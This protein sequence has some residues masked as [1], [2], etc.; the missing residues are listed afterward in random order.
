VGFVKIAWDIFQGGIALTVG[1]LL[2]LGHNNYAFGAGILLTAL[3]CR[4]FSD[5]LGES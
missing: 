1:I 4:C 2:I 5:A 3:A